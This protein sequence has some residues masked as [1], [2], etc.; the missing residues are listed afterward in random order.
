MLFIILIPIDLEPFGAE[1]LGWA[2]EPQ[3]RAHQDLG[4]LVGMLR[5]RHPT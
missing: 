4:V 3:R 2:K 1:L 5:F